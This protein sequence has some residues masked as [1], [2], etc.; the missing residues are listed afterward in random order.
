MTGHPRHLGIAK[1]L[2]ANLMIG[3]DQLPFG[4]DTTDFFRE[5]WSGKGREDEEQDAVFHGGPDFR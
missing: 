5:G 4:G 1:R 3:A 2:D